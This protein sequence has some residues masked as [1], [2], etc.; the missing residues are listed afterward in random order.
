MSRTLETAKPARRARANT[1]WDWVSRNGGIEPANNNADQLAAPQPAEETHEATRLREFLESGGIAAWTE[2]Q[3]RVFYLHFG[4][5]LSQREV[6][7]R[8]GIFQQQ[9]TRVRAQVLKKLKAVVTKS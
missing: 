8:L 7:R 6:A 2:L 5:G 9:V 4:H 1:Y 3:R